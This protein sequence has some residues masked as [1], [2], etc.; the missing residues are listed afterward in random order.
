MKEIFPI[1]SNAFTTHPSSSTR[2]N[3]LFYNKSNPKKVSS[4]L[5]TLR[6]LGPRIWNI[7]PLEI[8]ESESLSLFKG[9]IKKWTPVNCPCRLC[10][11]FI[12]MLG[13]L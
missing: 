12:P 11:T 4:G 13:F 3:S 8:R 7:I 6:H 5:E 10:K 2:S 9:K 1:N